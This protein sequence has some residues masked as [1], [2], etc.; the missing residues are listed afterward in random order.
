MKYNS[1]KNSFHQFFFSFS[2]SY[3]ASPVPRLGGTALQMHCR[4]YKEGTVVP[5]ITMTAAKSDHT[6]GKIQD[7]RA[8]ATE[9]QC[10]LILILSIH[11]LV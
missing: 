6:T 2:P 1:K 10:N 5:L 11:P 4:F 7:K 8:V 3:K 9:P